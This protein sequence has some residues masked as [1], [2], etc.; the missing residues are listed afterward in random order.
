VQIYLQSRVCRHALQND[1]FIIL[2]FTVK[3]IESKQTIH[4]FF[5]KRRR[6]SSVQYVIHI[7]SN[8]KQRY[9]YILTLYNT[10]MLGRGYLFALQEF[11]MKER[12]TRKYCSSS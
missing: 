8:Q 11:I 9:T 10:I 6:G 1:K 12:V 5:I 4:I 3:Y 2:P 7:P